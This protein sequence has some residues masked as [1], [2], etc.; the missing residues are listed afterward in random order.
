MKKKTIVWICSEAAPFAKSGGLADVSGALPA[1]LA[2]RGHHLHVIMPFYPQIMGRYNQKLKVRYQGLG[3]PLGHWNEWAQILDIRISERLCFHF[4]EHHRFFDRPSLYDHNGVEFAD[5]PERFIFFSR[6][7]MQAVLAMRLKPDIIHAND[8]HSALACVYLRSPLY[9]QFDNFSHCAS[10]VTIHNIAYQ[11]NFEKSKMPLTGL[12]WQYFNSHCLEFHD[13]LCLLKGGVM[14]AHAVNTVSPTYAL[15]TLSPEYGF[16]LDPSLRERA[17]NGDYKGILNGIDS[18]EWNPESDKLIPSNFTRERMA[19]K[20]VCKRKLQR[21]MSLPERS[22]VPLFGLVSRLAYQKGIDIFASCVEEALLKDEMQFVILG[23]GEPFLQTRLSYLASKH[24]EKIA[25]KIGFDNRLAHMIEAG[26]D[27]FLM[28]S[29]YE[30]CGLNQM[31]S[32]RYGTAPLVRATGGLDDTVS[33]FDYAN[34]SAST[35]FKFWDLNPRS[36]LD[37]MRWAASVYRNKPQSFKAMQKNMML[38]DFSW[39]RTA[40]EYEKLYDNAAGRL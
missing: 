1:A 31:Y 40:G 13:R 23:S 5:N 38:Q 35:G 8:W 22:D 10:I 2:D 36:L 6:A 12:G 17:M 14:T 32:M 3:V 16:S 18:D 21:E 34:P 25:V 19:G 4:I 24:P 39:N 11:G 30:P 26:S 9:R 33:N 27:I 15:E 29:R 20:K 28:P 37:T 7:A